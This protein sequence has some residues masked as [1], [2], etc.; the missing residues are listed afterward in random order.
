MWLWDP[1]GIFTVKSCYNF[2][3]FGGVR[4]QAR[5]T[6]WHLKVPLKIRLFLW[7]IFQNKILTK[8]N[9]C[10]KGWQG[11]TLCPFCSH[12]ES[13]HHLFFECAFA[14]NFWQI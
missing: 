4:I 14:D 13:I 8:D 2:L 1:K 10:K 6:V 7:L 3:S 5:D 9:L 12:N 11:C